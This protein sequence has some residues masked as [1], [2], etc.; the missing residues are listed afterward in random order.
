VILYVE[1]KKKTLI[2]QLGVGDEPL[3][4]LPEGKT[5]PSRSALEEVIEELR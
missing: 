5:R 2:D 1:S 4:T 3:G